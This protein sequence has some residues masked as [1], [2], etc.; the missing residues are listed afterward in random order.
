MHLVPDGSG[1]W[2]HTHGMQYFGLPDLE[3]RFR[4]EEN[5]NEYHALL[6]N[7]AAYTINTGAMDVDPRATS[8]KVQG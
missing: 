1:M 2:I 6:A 5:V 4:D 3:V 7:A 8:G